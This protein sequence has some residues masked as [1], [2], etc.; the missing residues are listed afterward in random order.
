EKTKQPK[1]EKTD[2]G[3]IIRIIFESIAMK[4]AYGIRALKDITREPVDLIYLIG[5]GN[6]IGLLN[7]MIASSTATKIIIGPTQASST[8][9]ALLQ[10]YGC[11]EL[12]SLEEIREVVHNSFE[13][14]VLMPLNSSEWEKRFN[15]FCD[16]CNLKTYG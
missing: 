7:Q 5:G 2:L 9:N 12:N 13:E 4:C 16:L 3:Q 15:Y 6:G 8:G 11:Q 1:P 10:A 14:N